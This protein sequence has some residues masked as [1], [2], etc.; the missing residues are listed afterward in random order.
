MIMQFV[1]IHQLLLKQLIPKSKHGIDKYAICINRIQICICL[2][3]LLCIIM[4]YQTSAYKYT[5]LSD[6]HD[7]S[8]SLF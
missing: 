6:F 8:M 1:S 3:L 5:M 2:I 7:A 4:N